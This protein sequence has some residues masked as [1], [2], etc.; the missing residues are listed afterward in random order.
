M[1]AATSSAQTTRLPHGGAR[2][3]REGGAV[4]STPGVPNQ[5]NGFP[6]GIPYAPSARAAGGFRPVL[7]EADRFSGKASSAPTA[8]GL[9]AGWDRLAPRQDNRCSQ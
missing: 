6:P 2:R 4:G 9:G 3:F 8:Y 7:G 1:F 5:K